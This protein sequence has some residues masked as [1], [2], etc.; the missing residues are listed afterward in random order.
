[1]GLRETSYPLVQ[2]PVGRHEPC[3]SG[4]DGR[5]QQ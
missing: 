1:M 4:E 3:L 5:I 2:D